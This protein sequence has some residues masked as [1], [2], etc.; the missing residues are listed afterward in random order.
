LIEKLFKEEHMRAIRCPAAVI[1]MLLIVMNMIVYAEGQEQVKPQKMVWF[2]GA[3]TYHYDDPVPYL[4]K[5]LAGTVRDQEVLD[6][7]KEVCKDQKTIAHAHLPLIAAAL[8]PLKHTF[9]ICYPDENMIKANSRKIREFFESPSAVPGSLT[10]QTF[11]FQSRGDVS[12]LMGGNEGSTLL[13]IPADPLILKDASN[14]IDENGL[15][16]EKALLAGAKS[17][18]WSKHSRITNLTPGGTSYLFEMHTGP[19]IIFMDQGGLITQCY[20]VIIQPGSKNE[21]IAEKTC[22]APRSRFGVKDSG[23]K[24]GE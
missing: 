21:L 3:G 23:E 19:W 17:D 18:E 20:R 11:S 8:E 4:N 1:V 24:R 13:A 16:L 10:I 15:P 9:S 22:C 12:V 5:V 7:L 6:I 2:D 14:E